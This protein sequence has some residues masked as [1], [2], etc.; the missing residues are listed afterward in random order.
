[1]APPRV[2]LVT[3]GSHPELTEDDR[4][5]LAELWSLGVEAAP[6]VWDDASADW[7]SFDAAVLRSPWDYHLSPAAFLAWLSRLEAL[8]VPLWNPPGV[9]RANA[10]KRYLKE[11]E[12][13]GVPVAPTAWVARGGKADLDALLS[14]RGW[15]DAVVKPAVSAGA[16][17]T[18]RVKPGEEGRRALEEVLAHSDAMVQPFLPEIAAEGEW[19]FVFL[20]GRF[21]HAVLKT[22]RAGDFRV[23]EEHGGR[24]RRAEPPPG[25]LVQARD[26]LL[27]CPGP[28]LYARIDGVRRDG[29]LLLVEAE[30]TE[31]SLYLSLCP[32]AAGL[33]AR[34]IKD[35]L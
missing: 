32:G 34:L 24:V 23:Q 31:P 16:F 3:C 17:R 19:S 26:A 35:R 30:L 21:S 28:T 1:M 14:A 7:K 27:A 25:L 4:P 22:V 11:L 15:T 13:A 20:D 29:S 6:A 33:F 8:G 5:L 12:A 10:D 18:S 2:A 9:V